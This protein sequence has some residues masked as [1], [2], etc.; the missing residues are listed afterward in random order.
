M[1][2]NFDV[3]LDAVG[4]RSAEAGVSVRSELEP[5]GG[6][7]AP[8]KPAVYAGGRYQLDRR[9][10]PGADE[11]VDVVVIDNVPSEANRMEAALLLHRETLGLPVFELD[12]GSVGELPP[13]VP[14]VLTSFDLPHRHADAYLRDSLIASTSEPFLKSDIGRALLAASATRPEALLRWMPQ[15]LVYG[16]WHSH[17]GKKGAQTKFA[18]VVDA[19][20][21]G[22]Q[23]A[24]VETRRLGL[25]GD[26]LNLSIDEA[27]TFDA[28]DQSVWALGQAGK[29]GGRKAKD[30]LAEIGHGQVPVSGEDA[31][32]GA[33]SFRG[34]DQLVTVSFARLRTVE[35]GDPARNAA[36]RALLASL[37]LVGIEAS[38]A[39]AFTLRSGCDLRPLQR[40][41]VWRG[42]QGDREVAPLGIESAVQLFREA[43][44]HAEGVGLPVG[45]A[46]ARDPVELVP[47]PELAKVIS[48]TFGLDR[49]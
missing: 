18:R 16:W 2:L 34:I 28:D 10:R 45:G 38:F 35:L 12:I 21:I 31:P 22:Y 6:P 47:N 8:V 5:L 42:A 43:V 46:W 36:A 33:V 13:H 20:I 24:S 27:V 19:E 40:T 48:K 17:L 7:G 14:E 39:G 29:A 32:L 15:S 11:P 41:F 4:D 25:K 49:S 9:W 26:P 3:V 23:P 30:S 37:A 44:D 1:Q